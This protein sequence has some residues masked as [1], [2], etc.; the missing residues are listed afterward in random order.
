MTPVSSKHWK[1]IRRWLPG[2]L[3]SL[4]A[5][6]AVA[7][8]A[9]WSDLKQAFSS[10][11]PLNLAGYVVLTMLSFYLRAVAWQ[12]LL[13]YKTGVWKALLVINEGYL[14]NNIFPL[15]A[16]EIG[17]AVFM[18][19]ETK[20]GSFHVLSSIV[21]ERAFD[22]AFA[23]ILLI[24][25]LP[26][27]LGMGWIKPIAWASL[28]I[29]ILGLL[30]LWLAARNSQR[31]HGWGVKLGQ[32]WSL[33]NKYVVP[34]LDHLL[35]GL[36]PLTDPKRFLKSLS[37]YALSWVIWVSIYWIMLLPIAPAAPFWWGIFT[38]TVL[39]LGI[40]VPSAPGGLGVF[41]AAIVGALS[42]LGVSAS[43]ALAYAIEMHILNYIITAILGFW[44]LA[45][46]GQ[47]LS[48]VFSEIRIEEKT[49][50]I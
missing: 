39:A 4:V 38:D 47:S 13:D 7:H 11:R 1:N 30:S 9:S 36:S 29:V 15:R 42:L 26:L 43:A 17:R 3:I 34:Q 41:E 22:L 8:F 46:E 44:G 49:D 25:T 19:R 10:M 35:E 23:A 21:I 37:F 6:F 45:R 48:K 2:V 18:G 50:E 5:I 31:V 20:M 40:A 32:R 33:F 27:A 14:L 12:N 28:I 24:F 16:G